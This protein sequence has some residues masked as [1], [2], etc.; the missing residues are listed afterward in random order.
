MSTSTKLHLYGLYKQAV[1]G[2]APAKPP[3]VWAGFDEA[4]KWRAW[5]KQRSLAP[6]VAM[7]QYAQAVAEV[8]DSA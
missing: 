7:Q 6:V 4:A 8:D 1:F 5:D 2:G 3:S